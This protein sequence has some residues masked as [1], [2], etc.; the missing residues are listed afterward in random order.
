MNTTNT[1]ESLITND[2]K[3][4]EQLE[5][6]NPIIF[7]PG[8][9]DASAKFNF[10]RYC[11]DYERS[12][13]VAEAIVNTKPHFHSFWNEREKEFLTGLL[14]ATAE[15]SEPTPANL[16]KLLHS[17][18]ENILSL[19]DHSPNPNVKNSANSLRKQIKCEI[20]D[21]LRGMI[22]KLSVLNDPEMLKFTD[23]ADTFDFARL[24]T[25]PTQIFWNM[26]RSISPNALTPLF[27]SLA[28]KDFLE[29]YKGFNVR[30]LIPDLSDLGRIHKLERNIVLFR[31]QNIQLET[32]VKDTE[33]FQEIYGR[34][35]ADM[36]IA[37]LNSDRAQEIYK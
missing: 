17:G 5:K 16:F 37:N 6:T 15:S 9:P 23:T 24:R 22:K 28:F 33:V 21:V 10:V 34:S 1:Q 12:C 31:D 11:T 29:N 27:F 18:Q 26:P 32:G 13:D 14:L 3:I 8:E 35:D 19:I 2:S 4:F 7:S 25:K 20:G 30:F 36:I